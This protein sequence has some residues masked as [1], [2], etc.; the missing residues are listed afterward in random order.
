MV[1]TRKLCLHCC[2]LLQPFVSMGCWPRP[3]INLYVFRLRHRIVSVATQNTLDAS[4]CRRSTSAA[5]SRRCCV[6]IFTLLSL[7]NKDVIT[8]NTYCQRLARFITCYKL[9]KLQST[10]I[11]GNLYLTQKGSATIE[12]VN[13]LSDAHL[14]LSAVQSCTSNIPCPLRQALLSLQPNCTWPTDALHTA[15]LLNLAAPTSS[16]AAA[17]IMLSC[18]TAWQSTQQRCCGCSCAVH[19]MLVGSPAPASASLPCTT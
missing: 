6:H 15:A 1:G 3:H 7:Q 10:F 16:P 12:H 19:P 9:V 4:A 5:T 18:I 8:S 11:S 14:L 2:C 13:L 17:G